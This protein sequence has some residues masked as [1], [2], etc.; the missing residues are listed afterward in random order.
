MARTR[1]RRNT[2]TRFFGLLERT[3]FMVFSTEASTVVEHAL[4][5]ASQQ[6]GCE[7]YF[8][9]Q[10]ESPL[11]FTILLRKVI[12]CIPFINRLPLFA[13]VRM[14]ADVAGIVARPLDPEAKADT[15]QAAVE[16]IVNDPQGLDGVTMMKGDTLR[17]TRGDLTLDISFMSRRKALQEYIEADMK[18]QPEDERYPHVAVIDSASE[19]FDI[20]REELSYDKELRRF[21]DENFDENGSPTGVLKLL[22]LA[23]KRRAER[24]QTVSAILG[25][26]PGEADAKVLQSI[27]VH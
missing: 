25:E 12:E 18:K 3:D 22:T 9:D 27:S 10:A 4:K 7:I 5:A 13:V 21:F 8:V 14:F 17:V 1:Q 20:V 15:V 6:Y 23:F 19:A 26:E 16:T 11:Y 24:D 2:P